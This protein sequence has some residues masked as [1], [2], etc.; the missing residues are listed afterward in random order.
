MS[1]FPAYTRYEANQQ[2]PRKQRE[3]AHSSCLA[4]C[5]VVPRTRTEGG[6]VP[7]HTFV[8]RVRDF[9][10][11]AG[12][13]VRLQLERILGRVQLSAVELELQPEAFQATEELRIASGELASLIEELEN[14]SPERR[15]LR[16]FTWRIPP[17]PRVSPRVT[18]QHLR[19]RIKN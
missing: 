3:L 13:D 18:E 7:G 8:A 10:D 19:R 6:Q 16:S 15:V 9:V 17:T 5:S 2:K 11:N 4:L 1:A 14:P 12:M